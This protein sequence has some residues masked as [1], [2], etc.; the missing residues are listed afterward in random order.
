MLKFIRNL[1]EAKN[2]QVTA[3]LKQS[4]RVDLSVIFLK[5]TCLMYMCICVCV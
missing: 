3:Q 5:A 2:K 1:V 4:V